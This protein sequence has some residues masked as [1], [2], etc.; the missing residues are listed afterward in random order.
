MI[1]VGLRKKVSCLCFDEPYIIVQ[2]PSFSNFSGL[3]SAG[4]APAEPLHSLKDSYNVVVREEH[5]AFPEL[6]NS[7]S[8]LTLMAFLFSMDTNML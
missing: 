5:R 8:E 3:S 4:F 6:F 2:R 1:G 7:V